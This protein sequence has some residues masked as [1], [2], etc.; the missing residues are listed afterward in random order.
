MKR[1]RKIRSTSQVRGE[2]VCLKCLRP[3]SPGTHFCIQCG[4]PVTLQATTT[5]Y[6]QILAAGYAY[7]E[8]SDKPVSL[9]VLVGM[10]LLWAPILLFCIGLAVYLFVNVPAIYNEARFFPWELEN[11]LAAFFCVAL[12][13]FWTWV[14]TVLLF[15]T[16]KNYLL[17]R[18]LRADAYEPPRLKKYRDARNL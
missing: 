6:E 11:Y 2:P 12:L 16:T 9:I 14:S 10:W 8:A 7:R 15:K 1:R 18:E 3:V 13:T 17:L 4:A 5:P